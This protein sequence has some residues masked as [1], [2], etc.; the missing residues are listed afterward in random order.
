MNKPKITV[1]QCHVPISPEFDEM[2]EASYKSLMGMY[3]EYVLVVN[4]GIGYAKA[5]NWGMKHAKGDFIICV[6][7]D[8]LL[9]DGVLES[10]CDL[11]AVTYSSNNQFGCFFCLPRW[12]Y[13][14]TQGFDESFGM[15]YFEDND[16]LLRLKDLKI[17]IKRVSSIVI[18]H[19]GGVTVRA[20]NKESE[21]S[22]FGEKRF[23]EK[24]G[25][26]DPNSWEQN[27]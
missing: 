20:L 11:K 13:E 7:N 3:D 25:D 4:D 27:S 26:R 24:W 16:F 22:Q 9:I 2:L 12:V 5:H 6:S 1:V 15:A 18:E 14:A 10:M 23:K 21:A 8:A 17:P 19:L